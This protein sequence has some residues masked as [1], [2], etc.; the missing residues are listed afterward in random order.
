V[1]RVGLPIASLLALLVL[2]S[3][4]G[5]G[6]LRVT[7]DQATR[8]T[9]DPT[10]TASPLPGSEP[11]YPVGL[12]DQDIDVD[13]VG[14]R[15][16]VYVPEGVSRPQGVVLVLHGG[17]GRGAAV[18]D[19]PTSPLSVFRT[20]AD[21]E[22][23][24]VVYPAGLPANDRGERIGWVDC[25]AD[26]RVSSDADDLGFLA[27]LVGKLEDDY[28]LDRGQIFMAGTSN[29]AL[30]TQAF[31]FTHPELVGAVA[32]SLGNL[33]A[34]PLPGDCTTGPS[35]PVPI[36]LVHGTDDTQMPFDG[37]CVVDLGGGCNRGQVTSAKATVQRW[38]DV[39]GLSGAS[40]ERRT[41]DVDPDDGGTADLFV[42]EGPT[43]VHWWRLDGA[44]HT[45][46]SLTASVQPNRL[47]GRQNRDVEFA[48][49]VWAFFA[50][51]VQ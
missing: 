36:L 12:T 47:V 27:A 32:T 18:A 29:G 6:D 11:P 26:N 9:P 10:D 19:D 50:E 34:D 13:G 37:G 25:R 21:R 51:R 14:R 7:D 3:C 30:M 2:G 17:G 49:L 33:P 44:G 24:V 41:V 40:P 39:N 48:E 43:P 1:V 38:L 8:P 20:V 35:T 4:G 16:R 42:Y 22:G 23:F 45:S 15:Y 5:G 46:P 28:D 31:A